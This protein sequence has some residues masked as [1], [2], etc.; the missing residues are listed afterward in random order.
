MEFNYC[1]PYQRELDGRVILPITFLEKIGTW[2]RGDPVKVWKVWIDGR[3][4]D[5]TN[6]TRT[7]R[8]AATRPITPPADGFHAVFKVFSADHDAIE[9]FNA[10]SK[11]Y[12]SLPNEKETP[13][14]NYILDYYGS[15]VQNSTLSGMHQD[16][17]PCNILVFSGSGSSGNRFDLHFKIGD[18]GAA[19]IKRLRLKDGQLESKR[20][21]NGK[22][23]RMY[24]APECS[25]MHVVQRH[26]PNQITATS[27][28]W[29]LGAVFSETL[30]WCFGGEPE[31]ERY[32]LNRTYEIQKFAKYFCDTGFDSCFHNGIQCLEAVHAAHKAVLRDAPGMDLPMRVSNTILETMLQRDQHH[33]AVGRLDSMEIFTKFTN[34]DEGTPRSSFAAHSPNPSIQLLDRMSEGSSRKIIGLSCRTPEKASTLSQTKGPMPT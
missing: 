23:N 29:A 27:D 14:R 34:I 26:A 2:H 24:L 9:E 18:F 7:A 1:Q 10:E 13:S 16:I 3:C 4:S 19:Q 30:I 8:H 17:Q 25:P 22:M 32:R 11:A 6:A 33:P 31:R 12:R 15:F 5:R 28:V 21:N 20:H